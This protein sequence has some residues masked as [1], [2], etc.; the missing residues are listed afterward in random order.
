MLM[1]VNDSF[2]PAALV[3]MPSAPGWKPAEASSAFA[4]AGS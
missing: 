2:C 4:F 1:T 3:M